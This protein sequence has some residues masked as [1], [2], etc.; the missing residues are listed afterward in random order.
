MP[1]ILAW[2]E[3]KGKNEGIS[4]VFVFF[5]SSLA[6]VYSNSWWFDTGS[7]I[8]LTNSFKGSYVGE[9]QLKIKSVFPQEMVSK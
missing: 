9:L 8:Y 3:K 4:L 6:D 2:L 7:F 1:Q 5:E